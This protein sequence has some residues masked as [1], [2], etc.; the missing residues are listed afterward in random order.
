MIGTPLSMPPKLQYDPSNVAITFDGNSLVDPATSTLVSQ[1]QALAPLN[2]NFTITNRGVAGQTILQM[3]SSASDVDNAWQAGKTNI[4]LLWEFTNNVHNAGRTGLQSISDMTTYIAARQ[5]VH[6]WIVV[7]MTAIPRGG[8]L[9]QYY[10][11]ASGEVELGS[12]IN[13]YLRQNYRKMGA[14][15]LVEMRQGPFNFTDVDNAANFPSSLWTDKT[16]PN[17]N[18]MALISQY[19]AQTL[20]RLPVR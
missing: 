12:V 16:H 7:L 4:L 8:N 6:P 15:A 18:G 20:R 19:V 2:G 3:T 17:S 13:P 1:L 11:A 9:H 14:R 10:T 5:A